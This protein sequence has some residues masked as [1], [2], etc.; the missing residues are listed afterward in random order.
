MIISE[1]IEP[2]ASRQEIKLDDYLSTLG[3]TKFYLQEMINRSNSDDAT[4]S[5][6]AGM[7][8]WPKEE[9][10][11][12]LENIKIMIG[13]KGPYS[14]AQALQKIITGLGNGLFSVKQAK[15]IKIEHKASQKV[16]E[17]GKQWK[18][19]LLKS[20]QSGNKWPTPGV[21][22]TSVEKQGLGKVDTTKGDSKETPKQEPESFT[23]EMEEVINDVRSILS[24]EG[25]DAGLGQYLTACGSPA[26]RGEDQIKILRAA[27][28]YGLF[29]ASAAFA[30]KAAIGPMM[31]ALS[32]V[33]GEQAAKSMTARALE[34]LSKA[35]GKLGKGIKALG[36][37][38]K[39][40]T[41][42]TAA[43][44]AG[45]ATYHASEALRGEDF[46]LLDYSGDEVS[47]GTGMG[48][49][50]YLLANSFPG[51]LKDA[52]KVSA[53]I[54]G[55][56]NLLNR[57]E[58]TLPCAIQRAL[59]GVA[60]G[61]GS[62][63]FMPTAK[64]L[65]DKDFRTALKTATTK[66]QWGEVTRIT[67]T[68]MLK[69]FD[70]GGKGFRR[71][72]S[73]VNTGDITW[74]DEHMAFLKKITETAKEKGLDLNNP[75][76]TFDL[77]RLG[78]LEE[79]KNLKFPGTVWKTEKV[80]VK[81]L[82]EAGQKIFFNSYIKP[83]NTYTE[84]VIGVLKKRIDNGLKE[85]A[86][87]LEAQF[88]KTEEIRKAI[89]GKKGKDLKW[90]DV[91][92]Q[93]A[94]IL[95]EVILASNK[96]N[97]RVFKQL[98]QKITKNFD[99]LMKESENAILEVL[100]PGKKDLTPGSNKAT[101]IMDE[102]KAFLEQP[103]KVGGGPSGADKLLDIAKTKLDKDQLSTLETLL[104]SSNISKRYEDIVVDTAY[105]RDSLVRMDIENLAMSQH[106]VTTLQLPEE[107]GKAMFRR[108]QE[109]SAK[110]FEDFMIRSSV[111]GKKTKL[112]AERPFFQSVQASPGKTKGDHPLIG[113]YKLVFGGSSLGR[114]LLGVGA[115]SGAAA[116]GSFSA[117]R[118]RVAEWWNT[119][120]D[121][122]KQLKRVGARV[123]FSVLMDK[124]V[125][126]AEMLFDDGFNEEKRKGKLLQVF[127]NFDEVTKVTTSDMTNKF[128]VI[129]PEP[130]PDR[131]AFTD[132]NVLDTFYRPVILN[133]ING[134]DEMFSITKTIIK[135]EDNLVKVKKQ[136]KDE[137]AVLSSEQLQSGPNKFSS[138]L[139]EW[140][141]TNEVTFS[142]PESGKFSLIELYQL[143]KQHAPAGASDQDIALMAAT[144]VGESSGNPGATN[145]KGR[146]N[147][148]GLWQINMI[149]KLGPDR[150]QRYNL[151]PS[152]PYG[153]YDPGTNAKVAWEIWKEA[154]GKMSPWTA[155]SRERLKSGKA[156]PAYI[157][158][159]R[160]YAKL[161]SGINNNTIQEGIK[162]MNKKDLQN[163]V[164]EVL[165]ENSGQ[166]YAPY[167]YGSSVRDDEQPK[168]DY[169]ED[170][171][172][173]CMNMVEDL[174]LRIKI[175][176]VLVKDK[177]LFEDILDMAG[178]NQSIGEEI[179]RKT[180]ESEENM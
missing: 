8:G 178:Q 59:T 30:G 42:A 57:P 64:L 139:E 44:G 140:I 68:K 102:Y 70:A 168:E 27:A 155:A 56:L 145:L 71:I 21:N 1:K 48:V 104:E 55:V 49:F 107:A 133:I 173:F 82:D 177:E 31:K 147:S 80:P 158:V 169:A 20:N 23:A 127:D 67:L 146:D 72:F 142:T 91:S 94:P 63:A 50:V 99:D 74:T 33:N 117:G 180:E 4:V 40:A 5:F 18:E 15:T 106:M 3:Y 159:Q 171:K 126:N 134:E 11:T 156:N 25:I 45:I 95:D 122:T 108:A 101:E 105:L 28:D 167:P 154:G 148:F 118:A 103:G 16:F 47:K 84:D 87:K 164:K 51:R 46:D 160:A 22:L 26:A 136:M 97:F 43:A 73:E 115:A 41:L 121:A 77:K 125:E 175:A 113:L 19:I 35:P 123:Y 24:G 138:L 53:A 66:D 88:N 17:P 141:A 144:A 58:K 93:I 37:G 61:A 2:G 179:I 14:G 172:R 124:I 151:T 130:G 90:E 137:A 76:N 34:K 116:A 36:V 120:D 143:A 32:S 10:P 96:T 100:S 165:N 79:F 132:Q 157:K 6:T 119:G 92:K 129:L 161:M 78:L 38:A 89:G 153:L 98:D 150:V 9:G 128:D 131:K 12:R 170:W 60:I 109:R 69:E 149:G 83:M 75:G 162:I 135:S 114:R 29:G 163:L 52:I 13:D 174:E 39:S 81:G 166:G 7:L 176:K 86:Q 65:F 62:V 152:P 112:S 85:T 111:Q 54:A 110:L